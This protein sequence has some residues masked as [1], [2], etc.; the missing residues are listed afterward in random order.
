MAFSVGCMKRAHCPLPSGAVSSSSRRALSAMAGP[1]VAVLR[2]EGRSPQAAQPAPEPSA[3]SSLA[4]S[5]GIQPA[6]S[7]RSRAYFAR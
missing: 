5:P 4:T 1:P 7:G 3:S 2:A 6:S